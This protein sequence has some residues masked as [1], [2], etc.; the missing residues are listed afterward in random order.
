MNFI[1]ILITTAVLQL[2]A[3]W[4]V[5]ALVPFLINAWRPSTLGHSFWVS[6]AA[7]AVLWFSYGLYLH[8]NTGGS[9]SNRI[10]EIFS[11][12]NGLLL[13]V[14]TCLVGGLVSGAAGLSGFFVQQ[15]FQVKRYKPGPVQ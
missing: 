11:L 1:L 9:M 3:P 13:L 8:V 4:W 5:V 12:P 7:V 6:F 15:L 10:A 2:I 14:I